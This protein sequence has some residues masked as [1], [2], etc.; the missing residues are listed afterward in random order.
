MH[1][2]THMIFKE[3]DMK[4]QQHTNSR[5]YIPSIKQKNN[6]HFDK[7]NLQNIDKRGSRLE[8]VN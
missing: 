4:H 8:R 3:M 5:Y 2:G 7:S 6:E 1:T